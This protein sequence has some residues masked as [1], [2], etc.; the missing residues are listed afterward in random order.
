M[1]TFRQQ[2][3]LVHY[4][5]AEIFQDALL[6][7]FISRKIRVNFTKNFLLCYKGNKTHPLCGLSSATKK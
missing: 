2:L 3:F 6:L 4:D 5:C 1:P 7:F